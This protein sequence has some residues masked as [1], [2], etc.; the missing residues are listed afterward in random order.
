[1]IKSGE[2]T[3]GL[4]S[5]E[6]AI[7]M[8]RRQKRGPLLLRDYESALAQARADAHRE[9]AEAEVR[10]WSRLK[11]RGVRDHDWRRLSFSFTPL[12][13]ARGMP[14]CWPSWRQPWRATRT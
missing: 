9:D 12:C 10:V 8:G 7:E 3:R 4:R 5:L 13:S 6:L 11:A 2:R 14:H 1:M